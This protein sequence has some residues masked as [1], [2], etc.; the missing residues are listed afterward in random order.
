MTVHY[1]IAFDPGKATGVAIGRRTDIYPLE[2]INIGI[3]P[4]GVHGFIDWM[5]QTNGGLNI[6]QHDC[7]AYFP[8]FY[9]EADWDH[10]IIAEK[11]TLRNVKFTPDVEP[12]RIEG[13]LMDRYTRIEWQQP[14]DKQLVGD[15]FLKRHGLWVTGKKVGHSDGRDA[16][17][18]LLHLFAH[19]MKTGHVP[20]LECYWQKEG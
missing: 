14:S 8:D 3:I 10:T 19:S 6:T 9:V 11:F 1:I 17:D 18:A 5:D 4:N 7:L 20:T 16:N 15:A 13:V 12:A 2:V